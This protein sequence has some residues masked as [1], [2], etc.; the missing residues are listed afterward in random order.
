MAAV[1]DI[2]D[3]RGAKVRAHP[4]EDIDFIDVLGKY[5]LLQQEIARDESERFLAYIREI[6]LLNMAREEKILEALSKEQEQE[7]NAYREK[8]ENLE[9]ENYRLS[10]ELGQ[11]QLERSMKGDGG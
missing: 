5:M 9:D 4:M 8:I 2:S 7:R 3:V 10:M 6:D 11:M 1:R